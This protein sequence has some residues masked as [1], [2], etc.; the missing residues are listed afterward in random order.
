MPQR[1]VCAL[2]EVVDTHTLLVQ[3][4]DRPRRLRLMDVAPEAGSTATGQTPTQFGREALEW[5]VATVFCGVRDLEIETPN[6]DWLSSNSGSLLAYAVVSGESYN[7]RLVREGLSPCFEKYGH[8]LMRRHEMERAEQWARRE[9]RGLWGSADR[10]RYREL[11]RWWQLRAG[12]VEGFRHAVDMGEDIFDCRLHYRE[13]VQHAEARA[14]A[15]VFGDVCGAFEMTD[16]ATLL[17]IGSPCQPLCAYFPPDMK[18]HAAFLARE[19]FGEHKPNYL[20]F[21]G[22]V[23][24]EAGQPQISI[25]SPDQVSTCPPRTRD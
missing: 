4:N 21:D 14:R 22:P 7:V 20:Y 17:Q 5:A 9:G 25:E 3:W 10:G 13:I 12:Q 18:R 2:V 6:D 11:K 8:P 23:S 24:L 16:G 19:H 1:R 15:V